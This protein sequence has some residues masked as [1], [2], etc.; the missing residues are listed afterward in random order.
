MSTAGFA[1]GRCDGAAKRPLRGPGVAGRGCVEPGIA[2]G[3]NADLDFSHV[4]PTGVFRGGV[5]LHP[6]QQPSCCLVAENVD[7]ALAEVGVEIVQD[8]MNAPRG[9]VDALDQVSSE[10]HEVGLAAMLG[11]R[12]GA[13]S[14]LRTNGHEQVAGAVA[15]VLPVFASWRSRVHR[16]RFAA[17]G[18]QLGAF[19]VDTDHRFVAPHG[20]RIKRQQ[21]VH[22]LAIL[23]I[24]HAHTPHQPAPWFEAVF[25]SSRRI[26]S[27]LICSN[28]GWERAACAS[29]STVQRLTPAGG[30]EQ[31]SAVTRASTLVSY[32]RGRPG[33]GTSYRAKFKPPARYAARVRQ[34]AVRSTPRTSM[35]WACGTW[36][37]SAA[38]MCARLTSREWCSPLARTSSTVCLS[39][40][41]SR[42]SVWRMSI[43]PCTR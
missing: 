35:I 7:E 38:R 43:P 21:R 36:R 10:G 11:H 25:F 40:R 27:R 41:D 4:Q 20:S 37:S 12:D 17:V 32:W 28:P 16:Q 1:G 29:R 19:L 13:P 14:G 15:H 39:L 24:E 5:K 8:Q 31:A 23:G 22:P 6:M 18:Q 3:E 9:A 2:A 30:A 33:R 42:S 34:I 26:V